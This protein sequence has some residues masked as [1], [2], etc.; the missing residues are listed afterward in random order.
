M[1]T[2]SPHRRRGSLPWARLAQLAA[3]A[4]LIAAAVLWRAPLA[5]ILWRGL[6]PVMQWR[7]LGAG[8]SALL[9]QELAS[10]TAALADRNA[11]AADNQLLKQEL[12]RGGAATGVLALVLERP[13]GTPYDTLVIDAGLNHGLA[14]GDLV[15]AAGATLIG[16][17]SEVYAT[18]AQ[19]TLFSSPGQTYQA[20]I[21]GSIPV[22]MTGQGAGSMTGEVPA[23]TVVHAGD[24][25]LY[26]AMT[27]GFTGAVSRVDAPAGESFETIYVQLP[28]DLFSLRYVR[29]ETGV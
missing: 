14:Q 18:T 28:V 6:E 23:Q 8:G 22:S 13:P 15:F 9:A 16:E 27:G 5:G 2:I 25:V 12:G 26:P 17:V 24:P 21:R 10:T 4:A 7:A 20:L 3:L 19:V 1:K 29:V 11:L